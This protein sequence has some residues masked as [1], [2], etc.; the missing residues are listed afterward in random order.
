MSPSFLRRIGHASL[1]L[2]AFSA[3]PLG[4]QDIGIND[5]QAEE[6]LAPPPPPKPGAPRPPTFNF[7]FNTSYTFPAT[8]RQDGGRYGSIGSWEGRVSGSAR[9]PLTS[10]WSLRLGG[11]YE[12]YQFGSTSAP[13]PASLQAFALVTGLDWVWRGQPLFSARAFPGWYFATNVSAESF[14]VPF[15]AT[16]GWRFTLGPESSLLLTV[17]VAAVYLEQYP[18]IP[19]GGVVWKINRQWTFV[20]I[21]PDP[22]LSYTPT[23]GVDIFLNGTLVGGQFYVNEAGNKKDI[24]TWMDYY[25]W[26][27]GAGVQIQPIKQL[28]VALSGGWS[29]TRSFDYNNDQ[30]D[31][32]TD[33]APYIRLQGLV[34][35]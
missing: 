30:Q 13:L 19:I 14:H 9:I 29:F 10:G 1:F 26:R 23:P 24:N 22:R 20:G 28:K 25:E 32:D 4:A 16:T 34:E 27:L 2:L 12:N 33:G 17:G 3:L 35:F 7:D 11:R 18:V 21:F 6:E 5:E 31:F 8:I 15:Y